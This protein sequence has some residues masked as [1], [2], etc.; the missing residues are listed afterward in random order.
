MSSFI[1][2]NSQTLGISLKALLQES[3]LILWLLL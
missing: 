2:Y 1:I 3:E